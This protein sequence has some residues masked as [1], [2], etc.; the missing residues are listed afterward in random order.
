MKPIPASV[1][2]PGIPT[3]NVIVTPRRLAVISRT[4]HDRKIWKGRVNGITM[5]VL[6]LDQMTVEGCNFRWKVKLDGIWWS[7]DSLTVYDAVRMI[8]WTVNKFVVG[9]QA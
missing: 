5:R 1:P 7:G 3:R 8:E 4:V 6:L 9:K 2:R